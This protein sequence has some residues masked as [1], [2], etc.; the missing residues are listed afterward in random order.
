MAH[1]QTIQDIIRLE[2]DI[3]KQAADQKQDKIDL[4]AMQESKPAY[5]E[6]R[7]ATEALSQASQRLKNEL[8]DDAD[9]SALLEKMATRRDYLKDLK[10]TLS[11]KIASYRI[12]SGEDHVPLSD[13]MGQKVILKAS[14]GKPEMIQTSLTAAIKTV[15]E[16]T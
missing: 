6:V 2:A 8:F 9:H 12:E 7:E 14:L 5:E 3:L 16:A 4:T 11:D 10:A 15:E 1:G 13:T